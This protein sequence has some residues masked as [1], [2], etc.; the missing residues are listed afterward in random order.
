MYACKKAFGKVQSE[1]LVYVSGQFWQWLPY[2]NKSAAKFH[3]S[4]QDVGHSRDHINDG[5]NRNRSREQDLL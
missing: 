3:T 2:E 1:E 5:R 4:R